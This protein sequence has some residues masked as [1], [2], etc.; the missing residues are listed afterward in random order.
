MLAKIKDKK[1]LLL[2][3]TVIAIADILCLLIA[4]TTLSWQGLVIAYIIMA[5]TSTLG[6]P[7]WGCMM[8]A[9]S[10]NDR[11]KWVLINKVYFIIRALMQVVTWFVCRE[12]VI[13]GVESFKYLAIIL[14]IFI[15]VFYIIADRVNKKILGNSI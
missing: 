14:I 4:A 3:E 6:D 13:L 15:V 7:I 10:D 11:R 12:C 2:S 1:K 8:S 5:F 9:Y